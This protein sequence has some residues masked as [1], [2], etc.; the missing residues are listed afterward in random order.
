M[1]RATCGDGQIGQVHLC[2]N[3]SRVVCG[4]VTKRRSSS[5]KLN[6][7]LRS[8][9]PFLTRSN[10]VLGLLWIQKDSN[11]ADHLSR[12]RDLP[13]P[14]PRPSWLR[15][16]G[17]GSWL[18]PG[19]EVFAGSARLKSFI[20]AGLSMLD[21]VDIL[22]GVDAWETWIDRVVQDR[23]ISWLWLAPPCCS[24]SAL[25]NLDPGGQLRPKGRPQGDE[26]I[27]EVRRGNECVA[28]GLAGLELWYCI[29]LGTAS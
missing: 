15:D 25:R 8:M 11:P 28:V 10:V 5:F 12:G 13:P 23:I 7:I 22:F 20:N 6:G 18:K 19:L 24:F 17:V 29:F 14:R 21:P 4:A 2:L 27:P 26:S 9:I 3:D 1:S 16:L